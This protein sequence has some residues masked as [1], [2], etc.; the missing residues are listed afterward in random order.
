MQLLFFLYTK[1]V[2]HIFDKYDIPSMSQNEKSPF[3][4]L[5][6][7][8][9]GSTSARVS[10]KA[11]SLNGQRPITLAIAQQ[12]REKRWQDLHQPMIS[13]LYSSVFALKG[14]FSCLSFVSKHS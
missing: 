7:N 5:A 6:V 1:K 9:K 13:Q 12:G 2:F 3:I 4:D 8:K 10:H 14:F 11:F